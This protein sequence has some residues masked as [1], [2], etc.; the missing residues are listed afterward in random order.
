MRKFCDFYG[1]IVGAG[2]DGVE[3][4]DEF[5]VVD[6]LGVEFRVAAELGGGCEVDHG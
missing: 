3:F 2:G 4:G 5:Y 1:V 6:E